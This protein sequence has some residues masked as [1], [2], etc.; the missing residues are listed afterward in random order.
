MVKQASAGGSSPEEFKALMADIEDDVAE[1]AEMAD[2]LAGGE[3]EAEAGKEDEAK[4]DAEEEA[5]KAAEALKGKTAET[6]S[7]AEARKAKEDEAACKAKE[8]EAKKDAA[9]ELVTKNAEARRTRRAIREQNKM[10]AELVASNKEIKETLA[11]LDA[12][13]AVTRNNP[14]RYADAQGL[15]SRIGQEKPS[16]FVQTLKELPKGTADLASREIAK[17]VVMAKLAEM[18]PGMVVAQE[19]WEAERA[20]TAGNT[21]IK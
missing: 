19:Q 20:A 15:R 11:N 16:N 21:P 6:D 4:K 3:A 7:E 13:P 12:Q 18:F 9:E 8:D 17:D 10:I 1:A 5:R 14:L 2:E